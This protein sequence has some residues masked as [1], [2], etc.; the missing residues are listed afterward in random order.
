V[1]DTVLH[2]LCLVDGRESCGKVV[3]KG[4]CRP[5]SVTLLHLARI[6]PASLLR[7][8]NRNG[9]FKFHLMLHYSSSPNSTCSF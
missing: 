1:I 2:S 9:T 6:L 4:F 5:V 8:P 3:E 7:H